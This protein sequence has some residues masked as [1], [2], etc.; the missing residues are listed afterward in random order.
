MDRHVEDRKTN[1][2]EAELTDDML[3]DATGGATSSEPFSPEFLGG[4]VLTPGGSAGRAGIIEPQ[5]P[6]DIAPPPE[7]G[8]HSNF[9]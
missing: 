4:G 6:G 1:L 8:Y 7:S 3:E 5:G 9:F 2:P